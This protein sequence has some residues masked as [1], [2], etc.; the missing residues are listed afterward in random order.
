MGWLSLVYSGHEAGTPCVDNARF[1][2]GGAGCV[3]GHEDLQPNLWVNEAEANG[4]E[5]VDDDGNG[6]VDDVH[7][8]NF[9]SDTGDV[10]DDNGHG[11]HV[12]G[13]GLPGLL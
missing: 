6:F 1:F 10:A 8:Y 13:E 7:G 4:A 11:S 2:T 12:A 9:V 5:G 3:L